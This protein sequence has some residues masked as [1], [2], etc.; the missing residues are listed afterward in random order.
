M[1]AGGRGEQLDKAFRL[2]VAF[3]RRSTVGLTIA[4]ISSE[5][6]C[7]RRTAYRY[8]EAATLVL[9]IRRVAKQPARY[10]LMSERDAA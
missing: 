7:C 8:L 10:C 5:L 1:G 2:V 6:E 9:P 3:Q 4:D